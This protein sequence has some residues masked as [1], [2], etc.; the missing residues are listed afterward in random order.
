MNGF[1]GTE[2]V[3]GNRSKLTGTITGKPFRKMGAAFKYALNM[4]SREYCGLY[5]IDHNL[6]GKAEWAFDGKTWIPVN[7]VAKLNLEQNKRSQISGFLP[8]RG[9]A[10]HKP[11]RR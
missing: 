1:G 3:V 4:G 10:Q 7:E 2:Y 5:R 9:V 11:A 8:I 6:T